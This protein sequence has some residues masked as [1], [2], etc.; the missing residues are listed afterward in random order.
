MIRPTVLRLFAVAALMALTVVPVWAQE[1]TGLPAS[2][3]AQQSL[4]PYW[5]VFIAYALAIVLVLGWVISISR[6]LK[7]VEDRLKE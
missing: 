2:G 3:M 4:R 1:T 7:D 6:R 5:H